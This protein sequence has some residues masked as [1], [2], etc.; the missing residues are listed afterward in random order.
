MVRTDPEP[1]DIAIVQ[2]TYSTL[3]HAHSHRVHRTP[4]AR[5]LE[6]QDRVIGFDA[7]KRYDSRA[8][9]CT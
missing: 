2:D 3:A 8:C 5:T 6:V 4:L 1:F 7:K 9:L